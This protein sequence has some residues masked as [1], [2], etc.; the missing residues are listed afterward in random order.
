MTKSSNN[1]KHRLAAVALL[2]TNSRKKLDILGSVKFFTLGGSKKLK[3]V[4]DIPP[5]RLLSEGLHGFHIHKFGDLRG[6]CDGLCAHFN[7]T[8][9]THGS[10]TSKERHLGD[11][12]N[13]RAHENG[14]VYATLNE[15]DLELFG[16][17]GIVGR[18]VIVHADR[19]DLGKG[20]G[21]KRKESLLTGNAGKRLLCG[22]IGVANP[23]L[24]ES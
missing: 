8:G 23:K 4:V 22:V 1:T 15:V 9:S 2:T 13:I 19:D 17:D 5:N 16:E 24:N 14:E 18:S 7:P 10:R 11:L 12:G 20:R 6:G 3:L 21:A